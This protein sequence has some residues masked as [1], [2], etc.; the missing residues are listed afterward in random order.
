MGIRQHKKPDLPASYTKRRL[1]SGC[2]RAV[3]AAEGKGSV[4]D[5]ARANRPRHRASQSDQKTFQ[6]RP[7]KG[8]A[9][10]RAYSSELRRHADS[11]SAAMKAASRPCAALV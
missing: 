10:T 4:Q 2:V 6:P 3:E 5:A 9:E 1:G 11:H 8:Y 7:Y